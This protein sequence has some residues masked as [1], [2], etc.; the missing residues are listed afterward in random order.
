MKPKINIDQYLVF[1][2]P[3]TK[4]LIGVDISPSNIKIVE[5]S[6]KRNGSLVLE[7]Y[8]IEPTPK[9]AFSDQGIKDQDALAAALEKAWRRMG[10]SIKNVSLALPNNIAFMKTVMMSKELNDA[11]LEDDVMNE[12][13]Q[14][15]HYPLEEVNV[16][17]RI[18]G[19]NPSNP[20]HENEVLI[21][22]ARKDRID[23]YLAVAE[24]AGLKVIVA[25]IESFAQ[26]S[27]F[28]QLSLGLEQAHEQVIAVV[29]AGSS[30]LNIS[31][32]HREQVIFTRDIAF[33]G[34]QLTEAIC[35]QYGIDAQAAEEYKLNHGK[36][37]LGK[38]SLDGY[39]ERA[40]QPFLESLA[41]E[42][43]RALQFFLTQ[44]TVERI[45]TIIIS[46]GCGS[47]PGVDQVIAD[48]AQIP[49]LIANPFLSMEHS[50]KLKNKNLSQ[51][52]PLLLTACGLALRR[53]DVF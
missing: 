40:L 11:Q 25:D 23:D 33:G 26:Q 7:N 9:D 4:P 53:F 18:L 35:S 31:V 20:E 13:G 52:A 47:L 46:G 5:L 39:D 29:D 34:N 27:A 42:I 50:S 30:Q 16:D 12:T 3:P 36:G 51:E 44:A 10:S 37:S 41:M 14:Y 49:A 19:E 17:W 1:L 28:H 45:D 48:I 2:D 22:A 24:A 38:D 32:Y 21:C 6:K 43:N 8:A 15:V